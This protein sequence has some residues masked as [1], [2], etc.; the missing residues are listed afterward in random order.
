VFSASGYFVLSHK[1]RSDRLIF[2]CGPLGPDYQP[3]HGHCDLLSYELSLA[4]RRVV[5]DTGVFGYQA[6]A[7]RQYARSTLAHNTVSVDGREQSEMWGSFRVGR[8]AHPLAVQLQKRG[9]LIYLSGAHDGFQT[10][11]VTHCRHVVHSPH[12]LWIIFDELVGRGSHQIT[13]SIHFHPGIILQ[14]LDGGK[15]CGNFLP[16]FSFPVN[17]IR[18]RLGFLGK[19]QVVLSDS[20]YFPEFGRAETRS[21][22]VA[23][24]SANLPAWIG[25]AFIPE[26]FDERE[27]AF[28]FTT[29]TL[30]VGEESL[31]FSEPAGNARSR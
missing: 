9:E 11:G 2:D 26:E 13:S 8:R 19:S 18:Y 22:I 29:R 5:V 27:L 15:E 14:P 23:T 4:G 30:R 12:G 17:G 3:G 25:Y 21:A 16:R 6:D 24:T 20:P 10:I 1:T 28:D 7:S 31:H